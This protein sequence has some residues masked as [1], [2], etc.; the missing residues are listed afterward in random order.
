MD[1][2]PNYRQASLYKNNFRDNINSKISM[3]LSNKYDNHPT[4]QNIHTY[5]H[6]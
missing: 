5:V 1:R 6:N 2:L 4:F 3:K